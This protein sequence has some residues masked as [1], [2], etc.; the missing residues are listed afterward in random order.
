[1]CDNFTNL[2]ERVGAILM[3]KLTS[4]FKISYKSNHRCPTIHFS[5]CVSLF[6]I[7]TTQYEITLL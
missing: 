5:V 2:T 3:V 7:T 6:I 4:L 1:M